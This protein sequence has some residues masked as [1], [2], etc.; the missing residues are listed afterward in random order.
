MEN[1]HFCLFFCWSTECY[2]SIVN[3]FQQSSLLSCPW[4]VL[5]YDNVM[6]LCGRKN[7]W[8]MF[9]LYL[10]NLS[11]LR[12][13]F[14]WRQKNGLHLIL[15]SVI[16]M[17]HKNCITSKVFWQNILLYTKNVNVEFHILAFGLQ[18]S[19]FWLT[20]LWPGP[21]Q[22]KYPFWYLFA[23][24]NVG[25]LYVNYTVQNDSIYLSQ[26]FE[27]IPLICAAYGPQISGYSPG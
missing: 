10:Y 11:E 22:F 21:F 2:V 12:C 4:A 8:S 5:N 25:S 6:M 14:S 18:P 26:T 17:W 3:R 20:Q 13:C 27:T 24:Y 15:V 19:K 7:V 16:Q 23:V 9:V 1:F